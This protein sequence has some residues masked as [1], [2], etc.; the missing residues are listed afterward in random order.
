TLQRFLFAGYG[1]VL[2]ISKVFWPFGLTAFHPY[3][4]LVDNGT[5]LP[6]VYYIAPVLSFLLFGGA[7]LFWKRFKV[8]VFG[9]FFYL[10]NVALVLQFVSVGSAIYSERYTY[11][12]YIG[13]FI[14]IAYYL[15]LLVEQRKK[16]RKPIYLLVAVICL[17]LS[18]LTI[19]QVQMWKDSLTLWQKFNQEYPECNHGDYKIAEHYMDA[20]EN[21]KALDHFIMMTDK[22]SV[23]AKA[24]MGAGN[25]LGKMGKPQEAL[26]YFNKA[27]ERYIEGGSMENLWVNRAISYSMLKQYDKAL[28][29]YARALEYDPNS[30]RIYIDRGYSYLEYGSVEKAIDDFNNAIRLD[31]TNGRAY[32]MR[33]LAYHRSNNIEMAILEY[34]NVLKLQPNNADVYHNRAICYETQKKYKEALADI[35]MAKQLGK[36]ENQAY[37]NKLKVLSSQ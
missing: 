14:I 13:L 32:F 3:P 37:I 17:F 4:S 5:R 25:M 29:D 27:E 16:V 24:Y 26:I 28:K 1:S 36:A 33:A 22:Y 7:L 11:M 34:G 6:Y 35:N 8:I 9:L 23:A 18:W 10:I 31:P 30:I 21:Q 19:Q 2:Y 20:G 12:A 15:A